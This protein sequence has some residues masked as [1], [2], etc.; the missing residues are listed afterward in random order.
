MSNFPIVPMPT[1]EQ[2]E[3]GFK[4]IV[5]DIDSRFIDDYLEFLQDKEPL[6]LSVMVLGISHPVNRSNR[7]LSKEEV[8]TLGDKQ[9][10]LALSLVQDQ[11]EKIKRLV[12]ELCEGMHIL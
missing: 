10:E 1:R 6:S 2:V 11:D 4:S 7:Y 12:E 5:P 9:K 3:R 8:L